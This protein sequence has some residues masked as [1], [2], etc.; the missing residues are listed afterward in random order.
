MQILNNFF[1]FKFLNYLNQSFLSKNMTLLTALTK[2]LKY[3]RQFIVFTMTLIIDQISNLILQHY[4]TT[5]A[6]YNYQFLHEQ[7]YSFCLW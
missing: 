4:G 3:L 2:S 1:Y 7:I 6:L 5:M